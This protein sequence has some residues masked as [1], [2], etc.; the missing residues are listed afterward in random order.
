MT[1]LIGIK[2]VV[3]RTGL[4]KSTIYFMIARGGFPANLRCG[5]RAVRWREADIEEFVA[6]PRQWALDRALERVHYHLAGINGELS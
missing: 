6:R 2:E 4:S 5:K 3:Y 1:R